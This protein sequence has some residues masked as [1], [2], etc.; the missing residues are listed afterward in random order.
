MITLA[1]MTSA[2]PPTGR[3]LA[4]VV[5]PSTSRTI[6]AAPIRTPRTTRAMSQRR[7]RPWV[8]APSSGTT[9]LSMNAFSDSLAL[10]QMR[11]TTPTARKVGHPMNPTNGTCRIPVMI[12]TAISRG[13]RMAAIVRMPRR[14]L[15]ARE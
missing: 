7:R 14:S 15:M 6:P 9:S 12:C 8:S 10:R 11:M 3:S 13:M 1:P 4:S 5:W 2:A